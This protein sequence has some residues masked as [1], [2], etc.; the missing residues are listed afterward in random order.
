MRV[1]CISNRVDQLNDVDLRGRLEKSINLDGADDSLVIGNIYSVFAMTKWA[2]GG[3]R[4]YL[5]T[6]EDGDY[7]YPYPIEMFELVDPVVPL[8]WCVAIEREPLG[9]SIGRISFPEWAADDYFYE[10]LVEGD[11]IAVATY[12]CWKKLFD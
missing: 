8:G 1:R 12:K 2:D 9:D 10:R 5:H 3:I 6:V 7:P 4:I 11:D